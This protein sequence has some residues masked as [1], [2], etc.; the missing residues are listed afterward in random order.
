M[1]RRGDCICAIPALP[2][3]RHHPHCPV[4]RRVEAHHRLTAS[5]LVAPFVVRPNVEFRDLLT[6][7]DGHGTVILTTHHPSF[8]ALCQ[9]L[10]T[11]WATSRGAGGGEA[12]RKAQEARTGASGERPRT[13]AGTPEPS[14]PN[15]L[16]RCLVC[17][18]D[19]P[20][21]GNCVTEHAFVSRQQCRKC[22]EEDAAGGP[23]KGG[24]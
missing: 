5:D 23:P 11:A 3:E 6:I 1:N 18:H 19:H 10:L 13:D 9:R 16:S 2:P 7:V 17:G 22:R 21:Q 8:A 20:G 15:P 24:A 14:H 12:P 4:R